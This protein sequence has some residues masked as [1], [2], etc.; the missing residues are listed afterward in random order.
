VV[1]VSVLV[2]EVVVVADVAVDVVAVAVVMI[3]HAP[4][5]CGSQVAGHPFF[6]DPILHTAAACAA[7]AT[8]LRPSHSPL[9]N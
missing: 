5:K 8:Q 2:T 9:Q 6:M 4:G 1:V 3:G 7:S